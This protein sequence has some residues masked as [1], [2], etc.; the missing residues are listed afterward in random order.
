MPERNKGKNIFLYEMLIIWECFNL[1]N[2][3]TNVNDVGDQLQI[4]AGKFLD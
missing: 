2:E 4:A 1:K 3:M